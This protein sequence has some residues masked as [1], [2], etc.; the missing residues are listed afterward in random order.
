MTICYNYGRGRS[1]WRMFKIK[2]NELKDIKYHLLHPY[3]FKNHLTLI[4]VFNVE[5]S[6]NIIIIIIVILIVRNALSDSK[7]I[8]PKVVFSAHGEEI[9]YE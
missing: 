1:D 9:I 3:L 6:Q 5:N 7:N 4:Q 8:Q 2:P